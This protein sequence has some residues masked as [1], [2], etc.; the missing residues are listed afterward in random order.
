MTAAAVTTAGPIA[1]ERV[2]LALFEPDQP[3]NFGAMLRLGACLDVAIDVIEPCGFPLDERRIR[4]AAMDY[5]RHVAWRRH[6]GLSE[7]LA[8]AAEEARRLVLLS[9][10]ASTAYHA[11]TYRPCDVLVLGSESRGASPALQAACA[12]AVRIPIR[13]GLRSLNLATAGAIGLAE[14]LRQ[15][16]GWPGAMAGSNE[17]AEIDRLA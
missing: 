8:T 12:A 2:R 1:Q 15:L 17:R 6:A 4:R 16:G 13:T 10:K 5:A 7:F 11:F 9:A 3:G 14:V